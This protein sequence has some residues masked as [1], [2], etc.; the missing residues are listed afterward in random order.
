MPHSCCAVGCTNRSTKEGALPLYSIPRKG[1]PF[2]DNRRALGIA[3]SRREDWNKPE[4]T[5]DG[6]SWQTICSDPFVSGK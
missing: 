2:E 6:I 3:A 5:F 1:T 4:R